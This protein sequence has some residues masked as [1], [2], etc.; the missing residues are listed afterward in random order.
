MVR[1]LPDRTAPRY[2]PPAPIGPPPQ[3]RTFHGTITRDWRISSFTALTED[4]DTE[5][6]D[7]DRAPGSE[8]IDTGV[9]P[10]GIHAF[11]AG[12]V[13]G[14]FLHRIFEE[15][16][17]T[18]P[19]AISPLVESR[20]ASFGFDTKIWG[21]AVTRCVRATLGARLAKGVQ[22]QSVASS[23]RLNELEFHLAIGRLEAETL[24]GALGGEA[25]RLQFD[26]RRGLLKGYIDLLFES[27][28]RFY[29]VDWKTNR[30]ATDASGYSQDVLQAA[31]DRHH[32]LL[33]AR[34]YTVAVYRWMQL[35]GLDYERDFGGA[36]Y[37]FVRGIDSAHPRSGIFRDRATL[38][39]IQALDALLSAD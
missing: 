4:R 27:G 14:V 22:L 3:A 39:E 23:A 11:P 26:S 31:M 36:F 24:S 33:Q 6:P 2:Q 7:Y 15:L 17:F 1:N 5:R 18:A 10:S 37:L 29:L 19:A 30:L 38:A 16:D 32:Y 28:G 8:V 25:D 9:S 13:T 12:K 21:E 34:L 35:R 20:L